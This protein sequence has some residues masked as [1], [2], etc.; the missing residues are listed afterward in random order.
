MD[1]VAILAVVA[2]NRIVNAALTIFLIFAEYFMVAKL[3]CL[4]F[5]L[6]KKKQKQELYRAYIN[7]NEQLTANNKDERSN[8]DK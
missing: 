1:L 7:E 4:F 2:S 3:Q 5:Y 8:F 6:G